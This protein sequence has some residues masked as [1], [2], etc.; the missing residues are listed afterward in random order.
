MMRCESVYFRVAVR[1]SVVGN[2]ELSRILPLGNSKPKASFKTDDG[3]CQRSPEAHL[4]WF[5]SVLVLNRI[6]QCLGILIFQQDCTG[7]WNIPTVGE[8]E[9]QT[10]RQRETHIG[11]VKN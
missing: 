2:P 4:H 10:D 3:L 9:R 5:I 6:A 7:S 8:R 11:R 1:S